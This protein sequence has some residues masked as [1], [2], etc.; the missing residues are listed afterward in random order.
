MPS[1]HAYSDTILPLIRRVREMLLPHFGKVE[2]Q[3]K[4]SDK[5]FEL[6]TELD[7]KVERF[8]KTEFA[9]VYPDI[10]FFGEEEGGD[11][12]AE[13]FWLVDPIDGTTPFIRGIPFCTT[14]V[15]LI[16]DG[17]VVFSAIYD[18]VNDTMYSAEKGKGAFKNSELIRVSSRP[19]RGSCLVW[20]TH[21]DQEENMRWF[22]RLRK[23][24]V[25]WHFGPSG[26]EFLLIASGKLDGFVCVS[27]HG[28]DYDFAPGSLLVQEAGGVVANI[29]EE[30]Y[31][32]RNGNFIAANPL[33]FRELTEGPGAIFPITV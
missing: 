24:C 1:H 17:Q 11:R 7:C 29:G 32:Y 20:Q 6:I 15:A 33:I 19:L 13:R 27:P 8:L 5:K 14:M 23:E 10:A 21:L 9:K 22:L 28:K 25:L 12:N 30:S 3:A 31:D 2:F 4:Q 18:F 26:F 16:E